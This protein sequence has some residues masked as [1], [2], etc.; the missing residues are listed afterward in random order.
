MGVIGKKN[1][2]TLIS[3]RPKLKRLLPPFFTPHPYRLSH[4]VVIKQLLAEGGF[5]YVYLVTDKRKPGDRYALKKMLCQTKEQVSESLY[6][7]PGISL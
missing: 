1:H 4:S 5:G 2:L 7:N 6:K 3:S